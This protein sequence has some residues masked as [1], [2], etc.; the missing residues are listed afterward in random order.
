MFQVGQKVVLIVNFGPDALRRAR[1]ENVALPLKGV[2]YT[3]RY[4]ETSVW[5]DEY[6]RLMEIK[7]GPCSDGIEAAFEAEMFRPVVDR[8][9]DISVFKAMLTPAK[10]PEVA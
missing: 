7:N 1:E 5:G 2:I 8:K 6:I 10:T 9:T 3:V 4:I